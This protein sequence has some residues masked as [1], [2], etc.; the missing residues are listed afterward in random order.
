MFKDDMGVYIPSV[1]NAHSTDRTLTLEDVTCIKITDFEAM[2]AGGVNR[3]VVAKRL[4][5]TYLFQTLNHFFFHAD[6]HPGNLFVYPLPV[7][8][9]NA[10]FGKAGRPFYLIFVDFGMTGTLTRE[11]ADGLVS[12]L[13]AIL[14]RDA[15][16]LVRN[17]QKLGFLLPDADIDRIIEAA[18]ATF[19]QVWGL[20]MSEI[21][22]IDYNTVTN[23]A[24]EFNDL[25]FSMPFYMPQDFIYLGRT[26][27]I[28]SGMCTK[29]DPAF[30]PWRELLPYTESLMKQGFGID[31]LS[32][33]SALISDNLGIALFQSLFSGNGRQAIKAISEEALRRTLAPLTRADDIMQR[34]TEGDLHIVAELSATHRRQLQRIEK[35]TRRTSRSIFFGCLLITSAILYTNGDTALAALALGVALLSQIIGSLRD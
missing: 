10:D 30:N 3:K 34:L 1:Y 33:T 12:T 18:E 14:T 29:L 23:L 16:K 6:P 13:S 22:D 28:M 2:E 11:I 31:G 20:S 4:M 17:Y 26:I 19:D 25:L 27:G 15:H 21:R 35:E 8:D 5:E 24:D 7:E 9:E 32:Q